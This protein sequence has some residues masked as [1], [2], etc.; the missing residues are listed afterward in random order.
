MPTQAPQTYDTPDSNWTLMYVALALIPFFFV[1]VALLSVRRDKVTQ[2][3]KNDIEMALTRQ[4]HQRA[5]FPWREAIADS[6]R[7]GDAWVRAPPRAVG[8]PPI[9]P[10]NFGRPV[11]ASKGKGVDR[12]GSRRGRDATRNGSAGGQP[13]G[14][15]RR[16]SSDFDE[17]SL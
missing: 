5:W 2:R 17:V 14:S 9:P 6:E 8:K 10:A 1:A 16:N 12:G 4:R 3:E 13:S 15:K 11:G 7:P